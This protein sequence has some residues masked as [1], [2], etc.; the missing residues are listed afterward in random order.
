[1]EVGSTFSPFPG[2]PKQF[3][4]LDS[5]STHT[6]THTVSGAADLDIPNGKVGLSSSKLRCGKALMGYT[7]KLHVVD[8]GEL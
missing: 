1:M 6:H 3:L 2:N 5:P 7:S 8:D 4:S